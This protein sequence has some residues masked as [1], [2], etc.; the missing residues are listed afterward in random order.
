MKNKLSIF[1]ITDILAMNSKQ[2]D[3]KMQCT[4]FQNCFESKNLNE[5]IFLQEMR[6]SLFVQC[7]SKSML[8]AK[9][10][11]EFQNCFIVWPLIFL[12]ICLKSK[13]DNDL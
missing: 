3:G 12:L 13:Q 4:Q 6:Q 8:L 1:Q 5:A 9:K 7:I 2:K 11:S 10:L